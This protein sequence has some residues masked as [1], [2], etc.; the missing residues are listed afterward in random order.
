MIYS[1]SLSEC[2]LNTLQN[3]A[4]LVSWLSSLEGSPWQGE[5]SKTFNELWAWAGS[6]VHSAAKTHQIHSSLFICQMKQIKCLR[7]RGLSKWHMTHDSNMTHDTWQMVKGVKLRQRHPHALPEFNQVHARK[8]NPNTVTKAPSAIEH[9]LRA[10]G[11]VNPLV[12]QDLFSTRW[13]IVLVHSRWQLY[14]MWHVTRHVTWHVSCVGIMWHVTVTPHVSTW[15]KNII[16]RQLNCQLSPWHMFL[17]CHMFASL[18]CLTSDCT[19][20]L[21]LNLAFSDI[22]LEESTRS[23][24][25]SVT[26]GMW[27]C[28][29]NE[30]LPNLPLMQ[31]SDWL[32]HCQVTS[33][34][35]LES[36]CVKLRHMAH[37]MWS[38]AADQD[39]KTAS[40]QTEP[41]ISTGNMTSHDTWHWQFMQWQ[42]NDSNSD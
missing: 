22:V 35:R 5:N 21:D 40:S 28:Q 38:W 9:L 17:T 37:G 25:N 23:D 1:R 36:E 29:L 32:F 13:L 15:S 6:D 20:W 10:H 33:G 16:E 18:K 8:H 19:K 42:M 4:R 41:T 34:S 2:I 12:L 24:L 26:C 7:S 39:M 14:D 11:G 3:V 27:Q 31:S 30:T